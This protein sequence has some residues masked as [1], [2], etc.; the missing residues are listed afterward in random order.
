MGT[1][2]LPVH[3]SSSLSKLK[4]Q[5]AHPRSTAAQPPRAMVIYITIRAQAQASLSTSI[6]VPSIRSAGEASCLIAGFH[7]ARVQLRRCPMTILL[8]RLWQPHSPAVWKVGLQAPRGWSGKGI[9]PEREPRKR[10]KYPSKLSR[11]SPTQCIHFTF[12]RAV[13]PVGPPTALGCLDFS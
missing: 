9:L 1:G 6:R 7:H 12:H 4:Y 11:N 3:L 2:N 5:Q 10:Y 13:T 8:S